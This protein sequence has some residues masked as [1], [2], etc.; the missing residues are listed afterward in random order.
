MNIYM[1]VL[2]TLADWEAA[3]INAELNSGRYFSKGNNPVHIIK[4]S[5]SID[6]IRTMG[7]LEIKPDILLEKVLFKNEDI[8]ILPGADTWMDD[9]HKKSLIIVKDLLNTGITIAAICGATIA[10]AG[11]GLLNNYIHTSNDLGYLKSVCTG[12][13]GEANYKQVPAVADKNLITASGLAPLEFSYEVFKKT[14]CFKNETL[15]A[16]YN[17][18]KTNEPKYYY[19]LYNS[20]Q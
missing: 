8:L 17:L 14:N 18:F 12:Y 4:V 19:E 9:K 1:Y 6:T 3:Y 5:H 10:L 13:T 11:I 15:N 20:L 2:D 16:W 7:G